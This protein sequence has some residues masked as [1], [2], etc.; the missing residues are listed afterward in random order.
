MVLGLFKNRKYRQAS[1]IKQLIAEK[2]GTHRAIG[3]AGI[4]PTP[5]KS[6]CDWSLLSS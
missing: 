2:R 5:S 6:G 1:F 3:M 4:E